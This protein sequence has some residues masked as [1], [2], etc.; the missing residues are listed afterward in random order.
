M[1]K[2]PERKDWL[3]RRERVLENIL[4]VIYWLGLLLVMFSFYMGLRKQVDK[5]EPKLYPMND[6][7][8]IDERVYGS[9]GKT[10]SSE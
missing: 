7:K 2:T 3:E 8:T 4:T 5:P 1:I 6:I 9:E 10:E